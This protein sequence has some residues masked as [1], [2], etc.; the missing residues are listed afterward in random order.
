[1][2]TV[3][4][5]LMWAVLTGPTDWVCHI[6]TLTLC[7]DAVAWSCIIVTWWS[8]SGEIQAW[9]RRPTGFLQCFDIVGLV[10][11]PVKIVSKMTHNVLSGTLI[12][13]TSHSGDLGGVITSNWRH[14]QLAKIGASVKR[15]AGWAHG[16]D[17]THTAVDSRDDW[18]LQWVH[19][20]HCGELQDSW[21][22]Y[23]HSV[24]TVRALPLCSD[25]LSIL[26]VPHVG[27][28]AVRITL[29]PFPGR[30]WVSECVRF[31]VALDT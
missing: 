23:G 26:C 22:N 12:L 9:S 14:C 17:R 20:V 5:T 15:V 10:F 24:D 4:S 13:Y 19:N 29:T 11:W 30:R 27:S 7:I 31:N 1:M 25:K 2:F 6:E 16:M 18:G 21:N 28:G 3:C 8:G